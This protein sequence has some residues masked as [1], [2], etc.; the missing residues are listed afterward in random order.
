MPSDK[1]EWDTDTVPDLT[2]LACPRCKV[3][4][5]ATGQTIV[6]VCGTYRS[7]RCS[8]CLGTGKVTREQF[9]T[10]QHLDLKSI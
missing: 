4:G 9:A 10:W 5:C 7:I 1:E 8:L 3:E 2:L 6:E